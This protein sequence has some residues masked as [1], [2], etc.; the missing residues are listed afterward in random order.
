MS[1]NSTKASLDLEFTLAQHDV[2][3]VRTV[4]ASAPRALALIALQDLD[5]EPTDAAP[6]Q[7]LEIISAAHDAEDL[8]ELASIFTIL[9]DATREAADQMEAQSTTGEEA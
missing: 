4:M 1:T 7:P 9:G 6:I 2:A 5:D 3:L 8:R